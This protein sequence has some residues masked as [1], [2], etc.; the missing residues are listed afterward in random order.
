MV[1][2]KPDGVVKG[3]IGEVIARIERTSLKIIGLGIVVPT[4]KMID[5]HYPK[6]LTWIKRLGEKTLSTYAKY[7]IDAKKTIGTNDQLQIGKMVRSW[8]LDFMS[9]GPVAKI[10]IEGPHAID[11]VRKLAGMTIPI[12][13]E[14]GT[15]RGDFS[16]DSPILANLEKRAVANIV[17]ISETP[18]EAQ[19]EINYWF[20]KD[21]LVTYDNRH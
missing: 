20:K 2:L 14:A 13:A 12:L 11:T 10:A 4:R 8:L 5:E 15:I 7:N 3:L 17:H 18:E 16:N 9:S 1:L 6:D 19:H 21:E